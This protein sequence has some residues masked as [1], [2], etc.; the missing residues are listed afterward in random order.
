D[1]VHLALQARKSVLSVGKSQRHAVDHFNDNRSDDVVTNRAIEPVAELRLEQQ[2]VREVPPERGRNDGTFG[3]AHYEAALIDVDVAPMCGD[4]SVK[5]RESQPLAGLTESKGE[6]FAA[7]A[8]RWQQSRSGLRRGPPL[9]AES[10]T[11]GRA[12]RRLQGPVLGIFL[13]ADH[14]RIG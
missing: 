3:C 8:G 4:G 5:G 14:R 1:A 6:S 9:F 12:E 11:D 2:L 7:V 13:H 10:V